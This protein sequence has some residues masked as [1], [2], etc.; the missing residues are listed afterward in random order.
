MG[1][2]ML[3]VPV[4]NPFLGLFLFI[5][6]GSLYFSL[7]ESSSYQGTVGKWFTGIRV[8]DEGGQRISFP[9]ALARFFSGSASWVT[10]NV[11]HLMASWRKDGRALH[12]LIAKTRVCEEPKITRQHDIAVVI[13]LAFHFISLLGSVYFTVQSVM[14][15]LNASGILNG[16]YY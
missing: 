1:L 15:Q 2:L 13:F 16:M 12:D 8:E 6:V 11:G 7:M 5:L 3:F 14:S 4:G 9:H 10:L